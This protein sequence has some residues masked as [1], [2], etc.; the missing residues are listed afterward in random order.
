MLGNFAEGDAA[1]L[2]AES[3]PSEAAR[4]GLTVATKRQWSVGIVDVVAALLRK[5]SLQTLE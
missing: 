3:A 5:G 1:S 2:Y 4:A